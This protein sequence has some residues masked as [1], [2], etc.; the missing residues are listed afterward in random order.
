[1]TGLEF[2]KDVR[3]GGAGIKSNQTW[4]GKAPRSSR[5]MKNEEK[6]P[7]ILRK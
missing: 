4:V 3:C 1:V 7:A 5:I 6:S 2:A